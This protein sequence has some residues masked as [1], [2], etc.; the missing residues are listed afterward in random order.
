MLTVVDSKG[1]TYV[2]NT[3]DSNDAVTQQIYG[4]DTYRYTYTRNSQ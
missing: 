2:S 3:Y 4:G 1:Q